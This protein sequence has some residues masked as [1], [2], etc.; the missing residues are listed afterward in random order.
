MSDRSESRANFDRRIQV[1][2]STAAIAARIREASELNELGKS[3]A[4]AKPIR[5]STGQATT[6]TST[7]PPPQQTESDH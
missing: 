3:L 5:A 6:S 4:K 2:M 1:D 7:P